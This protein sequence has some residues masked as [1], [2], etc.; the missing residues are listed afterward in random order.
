M[1][2]KIGM[3]LALA[4]FIAGCKYAPIIDFKLEAQTDGSYE[5]RISVQNLPDKA[6][7]KIYVNSMEQA[8]I[9]PQRT[10][11]AADSLAAA[12]DEVR[13][14]LIFSEPAS[15]EVTVKVI[16]YG[17]LLS[18]RTE[19]FVVPAVLPVAAAVVSTFT[20]SS[21]APGS[22]GIYKIAQ[23]AVA[24]T[25]EEDVRA[26]LVAATLDLRGQDIG[27]ENVRAYIV[28][29]AGIK[30]PVAEPS[31]GLVVLDLTSLAR[32]AGAMVEIAVEAYLKTG[33]NSYLQTCLDELI[34]SDSLEHQAAEGPFPVC[35]GALMS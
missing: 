30:T 19:K 6:Q 7:V 21:L 16:Y 26:Q 31:N 28:G 35:G 29:Q 9:Y 13:G 22:A 10:V 34:Y 2:K 20:N 18:A 8:T 1:V 12:E 25:D 15:Y 5:L 4:L 27:V 23:F 24:F 3:I 33:L 14:K 32:P 17:R 11:I